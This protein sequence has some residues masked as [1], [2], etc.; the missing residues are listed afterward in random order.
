MKALLEESEIN[1]SKPVEYDAVLSEFESL[2]KIR[3]DYL[4]KRW[5]TA[6]R[7]DGEMT[8]TLSTI[9][10]DAFDLYDYREVELKE[11]TSAIERMKALRLTIMKLVPAIAVSGPRE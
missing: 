3:N 2:N 9:S 6:I 10:P 4:H 8:V 11:I 5:T 1:K 7:K